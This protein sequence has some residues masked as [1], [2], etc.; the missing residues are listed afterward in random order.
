M[1]E[2]KISLK[3][4]VIHQIKQYMIEQNLSAGDK[5]PTER[6]FVEILGVSRSVVREA[7]SFLENTE[8]ISVRHGSGATINHTNIES[9]LSN[10][11]FLWQLNSGNQEEIQSL[12]VL[13]ECSAIEEIMNHRSDQDIEGLYQVVRDGE[14]ACTPEDYRQQDMQFHLNLLRATHND[15]F[16]QMTHMITTYFFDVIQIDI[17]AE[18]YH[19]VTMDHYAILQAMEHSDGLEAKRLL[20]Q[21]IQDID[22]S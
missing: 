22:S 15:L 20:T 16:I 18:Q 5:L 7:L 14:H 3:K 8:V 9:L 10:F 17:T 13:I 4:Q 19:K 2:A 11:F 12:R 6:K 1:T 21:H